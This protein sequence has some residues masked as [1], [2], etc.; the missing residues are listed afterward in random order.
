[1]PVNRPQYFESGVYHIY[2]RGVAKL[3]IFLN[4]DD[5]HD[6]QDILRYLLIGFPTKKDAILPRLP[7]EAKP[8]LPVTYKADPLSNGLFRPFIDLI[9]YCLMPNHFHL[10]VQLKQ[11]LGQT[12]RI[13]GRIASFQT[14]P[15]FIRRLCI[16]YGHKF[17]R[18][19]KREG[20]VFQ[21]RFKVKHIPQDPDVLQIARY[22][23]LNPVISGIVIRPEMYLFSDFN[24]YIVPGSLF[25]FQ[26][27]KTRLILSYFSGNPNRYKDF[28]E[29]T[30]TEN[31]A[32][33][34]GKYIVDADEDHEQKF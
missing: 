10:L 19:Y 29:A 7:Q 21:G 17:N 28:I 6:F 34:I 32:K 2:N 30:I 8:D 14:I 16:T 33:V 23:H 25:Q 20:A 18:R 5:Y 9:A 24:I 22:I 11:P 27:T 3:P 31:E 1:M 12:K 13:D 4:E 26:F 15:E